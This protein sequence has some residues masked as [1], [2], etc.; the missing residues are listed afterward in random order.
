MISKSFHRIL[1]QY[2]K[3]TFT[4]PPENVRDHIMAATRSLMRGN[5]AQAYAYVSAL[6]SWGLMPRKEE[7]RCAGAGAAALAGWRAGSWCSG[8]GHA[9]AGHRRPGLPG[10]LAC[11]PRLLTA[12]AH[13]AHSPRPLAAPRRRCWRC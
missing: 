7:V 6:N 10:R 8:P 3:Q 11:S 5:W 9:G 13:R 2:R 12:P 1:D 4:G